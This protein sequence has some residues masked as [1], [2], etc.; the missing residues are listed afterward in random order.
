MLFHLHPLY[1]VD[2]SLRHILN[3]GFDFI[4]KKDVNV[5]SAFFTDGAI[6]KTNARTMGA[7]ISFASMVAN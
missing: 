4:V 6:S 3:S 2:L 7:I 1:C 5:N